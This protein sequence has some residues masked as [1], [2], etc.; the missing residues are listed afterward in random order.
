MRRN[1]CTLA[2][3]RKR[4]LKSNG[5]S[6]KVEGQ[7]L[8]WPFIASVNPAIIPSVPDFILNDVTVLPRVDLRW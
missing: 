7:W 3:V 1:S 5:L 6:E 2:V 4:H 8:M